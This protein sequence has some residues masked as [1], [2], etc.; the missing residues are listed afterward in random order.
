MVFINPGG[1]GASAI[2]DV[3][4]FGAYYASKVG[5]N[6]DIVAY[7]PRGIGYSTPSAYC[8]PAPLKKRAFYQT[9][10]PRLPAEFYQ[11]AYAFGQSVATACS[12]A[13]AGPNDAGKCM[14]SA[15]VARDAISVLDAYAA[16]G[17]S[18]GVA[19]K[20]LFNYWGFSYGTIIGQTFAML[21]PTRVGRFVLDGVSDAEDYY[22]GTGEKIFYLSDRTFSSF[23]NFCS[24]AG[25]AACAFNSGSDTPQAIFERFENIVLQLDAKKAYQENWANKTEILNVLQGL[26]VVAIYAISAPIEGFPFLAGVLTVFEMYVDGHYPYAAIATDILS[27][28]NYHLLDPTPSFFAGVLCSDTGNVLLGKTL[29]QLQPK[30]TKAEN[31][32]WIAGEL[33][34]V[35]KAFA[36]TTWSIPGVGRYTG[37]SSSYRMSSEPC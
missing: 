15:V 37:M 19:N 33:F 20:T 18:N 21:Y 1:P 27:T 30:I 7:E 36:C 3:V 22:S 25:S 17:H 13:I 32:S 6:F 28:F 12:A 4:A 26:K 8:A 29:L 34:A 2:D 10:G 9:Y 16:S 11:E 35:P 24:L 23:F 31:Q 14:S 5:T